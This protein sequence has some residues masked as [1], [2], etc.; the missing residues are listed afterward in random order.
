MSNKKSDEIE[1]RE[2]DYK[3]FAIREFLIKNGGFNYKV[4]N[5]DYPDYGNEPDSNIIEYLDNVIILIN[6]LK[7]D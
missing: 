6:K 2:L 5:Y 4:Y 3:L 7:K 1:L